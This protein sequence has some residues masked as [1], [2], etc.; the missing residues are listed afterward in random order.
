MTKT[1]C[2]QGCGRCFKSPG[3]GSYQCCSSLCTA[4]CYGPANDQCYVSDGEPHP[5]HYHV[6][7]VTPTA[8]PVMVATPTALLCGVGHTHCTIMWCWPHPLHYHV[9]VA[10]P[11]ALSESG[12]SR[13]IVFFVIVA[14]PAVATNERYYTLSCNGH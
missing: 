13:R 3:D 8:L 4:G 12:W 1:G 9:M 11:T 10:T 2:P 6:M 14:S 7:V 5:L